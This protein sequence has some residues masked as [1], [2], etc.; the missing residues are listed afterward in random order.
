MPVGANNEVN[1]NPLTG[2]QA[3]QNQ[4]QPFGMKKKRSHQNRRTMNALNADWT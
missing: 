4:L 1:A 3:R 2:K